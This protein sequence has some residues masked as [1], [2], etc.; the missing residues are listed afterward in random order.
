MTLYMIFDTVKKQFCRRTGDSVPLNSDKPYG[1]DK[2][3]IWNSSG[4]AQSAIWRWIKGKP[5]TYDSDYNEKMEKAN[6]Y[7]VVEV[8]IDK[9]LEMTL[10]QKRLIE[11]WEKLE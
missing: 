9:T 2:P 4:P 7:R 5:K 8:Y 11:A 1:G 6:R 3:Y 10:W